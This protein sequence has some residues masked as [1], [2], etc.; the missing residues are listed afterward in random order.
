[1][2][3]PVR[4]WA[5]IAAIGVMAP[6]SAPRGAEPPAQ[7]AG[8]PEA[9]GFADLFF[10]QA[11]LQLGSG[12]TAGALALVERAAATVPDDATYRYFRG[13]CLAR[14]ARHDEAIAAFRSAL[15]PAQGGIPEATIR[16]DLSSALLSKGDVAAA[17]EEGGKAAALA[18]ENGRAHFTHGLALLRT[19]KLD[20]A[21]AAIDRATGLDPRLDAQG[22]FYKGVAAYRAGRIDEAREAFQKAAAVNPAIASEAAAWL[23][24]LDQAASFSAPPPY[25]LRLTLGWESDDNAQQLTNDLIEIERFLGNDVEDTR[26]TTA[27]RA[28][29]LPL[30]DRAGFTL[31]ATAQ[32]YA[33]RH[34]DFEAFDADGL[35]VMIGLA[36]GGDPL[37]LIAGPLGYVRVPAR[38]GGFSWLLTAAGNRFNLDGSELRQ[39]LSA[40][41]SGV[42][43]QPGVG[44]TQL[45]LS[46][47]DRSFDPEDLVGLSGAAMGARLSQTIWLGSTA[48]RFLRATIGWIDHDPDDATFQR[49]ERSVSGEL[50]WPLGRR[51][52]AIIYGAR[53]RTHFDDFDGAD[54]IDRRFELK[55]SV[56]FA[57]NRWLYVTA[58]YG[59]TQSKVEPDDL[60]RNLDF[61]RKVGSVNLTA[62]F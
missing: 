12:D 37:G 10:S 42:I 39:D 34:A 16:V 29:Y 8:D 40:A 45:D 36:R 38:D 32:G 55:G 28:S 14:L 50:V 23:S 25:E 18:P 35:G 57:I 48:S 41:L 6:S 4:Y 7:L 44:A 54:R 53:T 52:T 21:L 61:D 9:A 49:T 31:Q 58:R 46:Y 33:N 47:E 27:L 60:G 59:G 30:R 43:H 17:V 62:H 11:L 2:R 5:A 13:V 1:M 3:S 24:A 51:F 22:A 26:L 19:D 20:E 56:A 15:P